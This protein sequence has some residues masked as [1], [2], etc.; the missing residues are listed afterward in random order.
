[1]TQ[2]F[3]FFCVATSSRHRREVNSMTVNINKFWIEGILLETYPHFHEEGGADINQDGQIAGSERFFEDLDCDG[4]EGT[5][6]DYQLYLRN[7]RASLSARIDF[8]RWG[9]HLSVE[10]RIHQKIY[11]ERDL[12]DPRRVEEGYA[13]ITRLVAGVDTFIR[14]LGR[15]PSAEEEIQIYSQRLQAAGIRLVAQEDDILLN[16]IHNH[17]MDCDTSSFT[18]MAVGDERHITLNPVLAPHHV[19]L[20][21]TGSHGEFNIDFGHLTLNSSYSINADVL[22]RGIYLYT[23]NDSQ[24]EAVFLGARGDA[25]AKLGRYPEALAALERAI[26]LNPNYVGPHYNRGTVLISLQRNRE[27]LAA[28]DRA[29]ELDPYRSEIHYNRGIVLESLG[30]HVEA[31]YALRRATEL[32]PRDADAFYN[33]GVVLRRLPP[34]PDLQRAMRASF[35]RALQLN[36]RLPP[37]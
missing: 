37:P 35:A 34:L 22:R 36:P 33:M 27:G 18:E 26:Q 3:P 13:F 10:N 7:N 31:F 28:L 29:R 1:M 6:R 21:G 32:N 8:F 9:Q 11:L 17:T 30:N 5:P 12:V 16:D 24:M 19:F 2:K 25:L 14:G 20:R 15:H 23:L 4:F